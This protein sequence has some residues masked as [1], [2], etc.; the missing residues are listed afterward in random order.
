MRLNKYLI[1]L[2]TRNA[3]VVSGQSFGSSVVSLACITSMC[4]V[5]CFPGGHSLRSAFGSFFYRLIVA[6]FCCSVKPCSFFVVFG[7][8]WLLCTRCFF[9]IWGDNL[10]ATF[11]LAFGHG[12]CLN[13]LSDT[14]WFE[15]STT[16]CLLCFPE[17]ERL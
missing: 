10:G 15:S 1:Q 12:V 14:S 6:V 4:S 8:A 13:V 11:F 9:L 3:G 5:Q 16:V 2:T 17:T 7:Y